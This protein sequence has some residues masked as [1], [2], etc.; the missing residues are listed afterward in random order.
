MVKR[1]TKERTHVKQRQKDPR[2]PNDKVIEK[3]DDGIGQIRVEE[4]SA[5]G[6]PTPSL[7]RSVLVVTTG[8]LI[9]LQVGV[10]PLL[11]WW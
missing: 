6:K 8:P 4:C 11:P 10:E 5:K 2:S 3:V 9:V 1:G 7:Q